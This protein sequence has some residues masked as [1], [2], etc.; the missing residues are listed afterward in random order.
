MTVTPKDLELMN[1][2]II[3]RWQYSLGGSNSDDAVYNSLHDY[4]KN[5]Y[6]DWEYVNRDWSSDPCPVELLKEKGLGH[7]IKNV[8]TTYRSESMA[9]LR[10]DD[11]VAAAFRYLN[12]PTRVSLKIDGW[13]HQ[14]NYFNGA[15]VNV[16][17]RG[18]EATPQESKVVEAVIPKQ[19][20]LL[21][22]VKVIGELALSSNRWN[23]FKELTSTTDQR[24]AV[25]TAIARELSEYVEFIAFNIVSDTQSVEDKYSALRE[26]G[27]DTPA[28]L[29]VSNYDGLLNAVKMLGFI[30]EKFKCISDGLVVENSH[31][32]I[33]LRIGEWAE[34]EL[35]SYVTGYTENTTPY[36]RSLVVNINPITSEGKT[37]SQLDVTNVGRIVSNNLRIGHPIVFSVRSGSNPVFNDALTLEVQSRYSSE[38]DLREFIQSVNSRSQQGGGDGY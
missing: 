10:S 35:Y 37:I 17:T 12:E 13:N 31:A 26:W 23:E 29:M 3:M 34:K 25:S 8:V 14:A 22:K 1:K 30:K 7:L 6:P 16:N 2:Y 28:Y 27:F 9:S 4:L 33:A 38:E 24:A 19:I 36:G 15:L 11:A 5:A 18:R 20:P 21:G 32:Q